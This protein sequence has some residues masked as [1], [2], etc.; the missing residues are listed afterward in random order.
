VSSVY[1]P[2]E[3]NIDAGLAKSFPVHEQQNVEFRAEFLNAFNHVILNAP[4]TGIGP[5][6]GIIN[7][8]NGGSQG[9]RNIQFALKY[10]F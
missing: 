5:T 1:G 9:A 7:G 10:N 8:S 4:N 2:G 3:Q 6:L